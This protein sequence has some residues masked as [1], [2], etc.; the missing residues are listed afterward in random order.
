MSLLGIILYL[1]IALFVCFNRC[2]FLDVK[3]LFLTIVFGYVL[4]FHILLKESQ[5]TIF[6]AHQNN[7]S[8]DIHCNFVGYNMVGNI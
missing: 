2:V 5:I 1:F 4:L 6:S 3:Y 8:D 7:N